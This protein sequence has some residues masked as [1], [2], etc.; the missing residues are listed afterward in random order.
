MHVYYNRALPSCHR[1]ST[2]L[3]GEGP[4]GKTA[5]VKRT[6]LPNRLVVKMKKKTEVERNKMNFSDWVLNQTSLSR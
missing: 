6:K 2:G 4:E 5:I 1:F 3:C